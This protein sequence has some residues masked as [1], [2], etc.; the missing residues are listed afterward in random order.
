MTCIEGY[1]SK[2]IDTKGVW[3]VC[4]RHLRY[5]RI[6]FSSGKLCVKEDKSDSQMKSFVLKNIIRVQS[7]AKSCSK[8][9]DE[10]ESPF[11]ET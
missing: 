7:L 3:R 6:I 9:D 5:V 11:N 2:E 4:R 1:L 8:L 10:R